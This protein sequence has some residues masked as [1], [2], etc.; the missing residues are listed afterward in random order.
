MKFILC[1]FTAVSFYSNF[2][3]QRFVTKH[4]ANCG[5]FFNAIVLSALVNPI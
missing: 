5:N 1:V 2:T 3:Q 4:L